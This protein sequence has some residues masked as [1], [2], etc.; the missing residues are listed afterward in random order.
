MGNYV[1][2]YG[3]YT[4]ERFYKGYVKLVPVAKN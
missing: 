4:A 1:M 2:D 3:M